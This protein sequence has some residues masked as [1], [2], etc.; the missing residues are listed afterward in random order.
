[1]KCSYK[2]HLNFLVRSIMVL[3]ILLLNMPMDVSSSSEHIVIVK[4]A[5]ISEYD[6]TTKEI[7]GSLRTHDSSITTEELLYT[8]GNGNEANFW[9]SIRNRR[10]NLIIT[11]GTLA[12]KS[13]SRNIMDIPIIF[14]MVLDH[15]ESNISSNVNRDISG[16][17]LE[18][19]VETQLNM[20][21]EAMPYARRIGFLY[22]DKS[23][24]MYE[25][26]QNTTKKLGL[27]LIASRITSERDAPTRLREILTEIDV[28]WMPPDAIM[29]E[30]SILRFTLLTCIQNS[31]PVMAVSKRI[32]LAGAPL[33]LGFD[34]K[35][36][37]K[38][39][40]DLVINKL[41]NPYTRRNSLESPRKIIIYINN[42][43]VSRL[44][45][46]IPRKVFDNAIPIENGGQ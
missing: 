10:P 26:A 24:E 30:Q 7:I 15:F 2:P 6:D 35:D 14:T 18:V 45:L 22:S 23:E 33:A 31:V 39:T 36:I 5:S 13:A 46:E 8:T 12:T 11:V 29:Y 20:M 28:L 40:A 17:T 43:V 19:P 25:I 38:Q 41:Q 32:A 21:R 3:S 34:Y 42:N 37:G 4:S 16:V 44:N 27:Q 9:N 1:M